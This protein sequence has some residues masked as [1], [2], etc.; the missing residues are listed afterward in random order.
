MRKN[1]L[2]DTISIFL[3][4]AL[5][6]SV[7]SGVTLQA[8]TVTV[9]DS[10]M[11]D[12]DTVVSA[13]DCT[14]QN[15]WCVMYP[16]GSPG[17]TWPAWDSTHYGEIVTEG[18]RDAG[19]LHLISAPSKNTG[20]AIN[21]GMTVGQTYTLTLWVKG[22]SNAGR[23]L[24]LY[25]NGD[26]TI[27]AGNE[28]L[29]TQ[30]QQYSV[31][32]KATG[33]QLNMMAVDWGNTEIY[34][35]NITLTD[36]D[37]KDLLL[38]KGDFCIRQEI[39]DTPADG[40]IGLQTINTG[41]M[42]GAYDCL[43]PDKWVPMFPAGTP[44]NGH[45][46][47]WDDVHYAQTVDEGCHDF[48]S[49][50]IKSKEL[51]N[52]AV[53]INPGMIP[54]QVYTV[55]MWVKGSYT[56]GNRVLALYA[57]GDVALIDSSNCTTLSSTQWTYFE[58]TFTATH[59]Q[60][61][62]LA[63][64]YGDTDLY[65]DNITLKNSA[66]EDLLEGKGDF[67]Q[68]YRDYTPKAN[69][70]FEEG[71]QG[72]H[73]TSVLA[74]ST[75][76]G[77][78]QNVY[79]GKQ[80]LRVQ[81][82]GGELDCTYVQSSAF[83]PVSPGDRIEFVAHTASRNCISGYFTMYLYGYAA[84]QEGDYL[85]SNPG[86]ERVLNAGNSWS[87][88]DTYELTYI[89]PE[90]VNYVRL[91]LRVAGANADVLVDDIQYY[92][93]GANGN[94]VFVEDFAAPAVTTGLC[95]GWYQGEKSSTASTKM[96]GSLIL[97]GSGTNAVYTDIYSLVTDGSYTLTAQVNLTDAT[98]Q[99]VLEAV[100]YRGNVTQRSAISV[101]GTGLIQ[102]KFVAIGGLYYRLTVQ[103]TGGS[104]S[105][106]LRDLHIRQGQTVAEGD[107]YT[108]SS[109]TNFNKTVKPG[110]TISF[111]VSRIQL[112]TALPQTRLPV[113]FINAQGYQV[114]SGILQLPSDA[115]G[116]RV[117]T[118]YYSKT[119]K[120]EMPVHLAAG[121]YTVQLASSGFT[122]GTVTVMKTAAPALTTTS[123]IEVID[124]KTTLL[125][126]GEAT[127]PMWYARP[128][129]RYLY[130]P[131]T[132]ANFA[133][134]GVDTVVSYVFLNNNYGDVWTPEGFSSAAIDE[135]MGMTLLGNPDA[136][137]IVAIDVN[138]PQWW[139]DAN[140]GE[141]AALAE[142]TP[143]RTNVSFASQKWKEEAGDI[144]KQAI[145]YMM[146]QS[147]ANQIIGFKVTGGYTL[148]WNWWATSGAYDD[149]GDFSQCGIAGFRAW[150]TDKYG[151][152]SALRSAWGD[153]TVT[154]AGAMPPTKDERSDDLYD[155]VVQVQTHTKMLDY[156]LYMAQ[157]KADAI[158]YF[159]G[160]VKDH[161]QHRLIVGTYGGYFY[162]G[163]GYE[164]STAV[165]NVYFQQMLESEHI[166]FIKSPWMYGAREIG[167]TAQF[168][169]PVDSLDLYGKLWIVEDDTRMNLQEMRMNQD[170]KAAVGWTRN[171]AQS[172]EQ[173]KRNFAYVLSKGMGVSY[174]DLMWNFYDDPQYYGLIGQFHDQMTE[175]VSLQKAS[176]ADIA[177]FVDGQSQMLI[178]FEDGTTDNSVLHLSVLKGQ[179]EELGFVGASYD[180]YLLDD[181]TAGLVPEHKINI[182]LGT[183]LITQQ[184]RAAIQSQLQKNGNYLIWLF[185]S[186]ISDGTITDISLMEELTGMDLQVVSTTRKKNGTVKVTD[187]THWLT[188]GMNKNQYYG[189]E[190][191]SKL[192]PVI[193]VTGGYSKAL[194]Y[195]S[196]T[197]DSV[198]T[199]YNKVALAVKDMGDWTSIYS[200]VPN[201]PQQM[202]R[203]ILTQAGCHI[204][205]DS[206]TDV[207]YANSDY[208]AIHSA[209]AGER[210][211][212]LPGTYTV[213]D[214]LQ[215]K[216]VAENVNAFT[217]ALTGKQTRLFRLL[218]QHT[219]ATQPG[220]APT[221]TTPG[222][223]D[224]QYCLTCGEILL[225]QQEI[226]ATGHT[227]Q[228]SWTVLTAPTITQQGQQ[229]KYCTVCGQVAETEVI[230]VVTARV[231][232]W[233]LALDDDLV[234]NFYLEIDRYAYSRDTRV[235][236]T[237][238]DRSGEY[239]L[240]QLPQTQ[241]GTAKLTVHVPAAWMTQPIVLQVVMD[242]EHM[243]EMT[244]TVREY[245]DRVLE[246]DSYSRYH[247]VIRQMLLYGG[248][249][250]DYFGIN[251]EN[252]ADRNITGVY[253]DS[254][255]AAAET[256]VSATG[257]VPGAQFYGASLVYEDK[258]AVRLY[259]IGSTELFA[260]AGYTFREKD[261]MQYLEIAG[262]R[263]E[264][265]AEPVSVTV[266]DADG[267]T[268][269]VTYA[270]MNYIVRMNQKGSDSVKKLVTALYRYYLAA[271]QLSNP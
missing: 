131:D 35:D 90:G 48:G 59:S 188:A 144:V 103:K 169:G 66:G 163:G 33:S 174:Y 67:W 224:G 250:Q 177:V 80:A 119:V 2:V 25:S 231:A 29:S 270:P 230:P 219:A 140:P 138:A 172:A 89:I 87:Q 237:V 78:S 34:I 96:D 45:W 255:P 18:Y 88:W 52:T 74:N 125:V 244:Y 157:V 123:S 176:T 218:P 164:F 249:A 167:Y 236:V 36:K 130:D 16:S 77:Y 12:T 64:D 246:D 51:I 7:F 10:A 220:T 11:L 95:G 210:T 71:T 238:G 143:E 91:G 240:D 26:A 84:A 194:G 186:G 3:I 1:R 198:L 263:P 49:L 4:F 117:G 21:A 146:T 203:N 22:T 187:N 56:N 184:E 75:V 267:N 162:M 159:C 181:L 132:V 223:T 133:Q 215:E 37:G 92:N 241:A 258:I 47:A 264:Q 69:L 155:T 251:P 151:T 106:I 271:S 193:A 168:M 113:N 182:F 108:F 19:S 156:E 165:A 256:P 253:T 235:L 200:A 57:N 120:L 204:Y 139:L 46:A 53:S 195:H 212:R 99:L 111:A 242:G 126:N 122:L 225:P 54:G 201:L 32:L 265:L 259:F 154:L 142:S 14:Q 145:D 15:K 202:V 191:Y 229:V 17:G 82:T 72:W 27:I 116:W 178:P 24:N 175:A 239:T 262:I 245:A 213:Y 104:G 141:I 42:C 161:I 41:L 124:G 180:M 207:V 179:L 158:A 38:G 121:T 222:L 101:T 170:D 248:A 55:G 243:P 105:F 206:G 152:D 5:I 40:Q 173:M 50:H 160:L 209:F 73:A 260:P 30:W 232:Q 107:R 118:S 214:V 44:D 63:V 127:A 112:A 76:S 62:L 205:T 221:C 9:K 86:Q 114:S 60:L 13:Y 254:V 252:P 153:S 109:F 135:M 199:Y 115:T 137:M 226:P 97:S 269:T 190:H 6:L 134:A 228:D 68:I 147:Y 129:N 100:D 31:T 183:T 211:V 98:G 23:V 196:T 208:V 81:R 227:P 70:D 110:A 257:T 79:S 39:S 216:T 58:A 266:T 85:A 217:V 65:I 192:S 148:E 93:Y 197:S 83:I 150:L 185:T 166:D 128:E 149:V 102:E 247:P 94:A 43:Y 171:Y 20:V 8:E 233:N 136:K 234:V 61:N 189:V 261:G 268:L 28:Q